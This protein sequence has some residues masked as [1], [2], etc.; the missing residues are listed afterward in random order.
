[1]DKWQLAFFFVSGFVISRLLIK[2]DLPHT[3]VAWLVSKPGN[4]LTNTTLQVT[5]ISAGLSFFIPNAITVL[6]LLPVLEVLRDYFQKH[7]GDSRAVPTMLALATIYGANIGGM[8]SIT[9]TPAN[10]ILVSFAELNNVPGAEQISFGWWLFWGVPLVVCMVLVAWIVIVLS[11]RSW[12]YDPGR[13]THHVEIESKEHPHQLLAMTITA[14]YFLSSLL[15]SVMIIKLPQHTGAI[16]WTSA[17]VTALLVGG[18]FL[19]PVPNEGTKR[20]PLLRIRDLY[21]NLPM[22]GFL[23][24][25]IAVVVALVLYAVNA[26][27]WFSQWISSA[28]PRGLS[29]FTVLFLIALITSFGTEVLSN[30]AV[31]LSMFVLLLPLSEALGIAILPA[32][33]VVTLSSTSAFMSPI[34][35]GVNGLAFGGLRGVSFSRMLVSGFVLNVLGAIAISSWVFG[36]VHHLTGG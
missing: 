4:T 21:S 14:G 19:V 22:R 32:L 15:L 16:L 26:D 7:Y 23:F 34:A 9:A 29:A 31:Q 17:S 6:T 25:G 28:M 5:S 18:L 1:M 20:S 12:R 24:V 33:L 30:T 8:G 27:L 11:F 35:T 36:V 13:L 2:V 10:G 3:L